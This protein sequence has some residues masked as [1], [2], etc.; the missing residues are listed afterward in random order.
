[1]PERHR[2]NG[3]LFGYDAASKPNDREGHVLTTRLSDS[4]GS[5]VAGACA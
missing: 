1:M 3:D 5:T 2:A 4:H